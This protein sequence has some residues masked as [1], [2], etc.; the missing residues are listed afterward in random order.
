MK[1]GAIRLTFENFLQ[2]KGMMLNDFVAHKTSREAALSRWQV[3]MLR[4]YTSSSYK[5]FNGPLRQKQK[6]HPFR[7]SV[8]VLT[9]AIKKLRGG[10]VES[11]LNDEESIS[12][13]YLWRGIQG[14]Y[15][16][17][18]YHILQNI[19]IPVS[20]VYTML[21][22]V[23]TTEYIHTSPMTQCCLSIRYGA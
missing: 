22:T 8:F 20:I 16:I 1:N 11:T 7:M 10:S 3:A 13:K 23:Y 21:H 12:S 4:L 17:T 14:I 18:Y 5:R 2:H 15:C 6:P 19:F 9:E